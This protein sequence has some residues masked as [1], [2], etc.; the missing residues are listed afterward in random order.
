VPHVFDKGSLEEC[1]LRAV[2]LSSRE[3]ESAR[4]VR[5]RVK[6]L[7]EGLPSEKSD[8]GSREIRSFVPYGLSCYSPVSG[9][10]GQS[11]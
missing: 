3:P 7:V 6:G 9:V 1:R 8:L 10:C 4:V 11:W 2:R 5:G